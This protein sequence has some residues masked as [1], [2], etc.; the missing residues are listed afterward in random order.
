MNGEI[1]FSIIIPTYNRA[2]IIGKT[3]ESALG[4][5]F[6]NFE[7]IVVDDGGTD[8][9]EEVI[10]AFYSPKLS[11]YKKENAER[12]AARNFGAARGKGNYVTFLD[13]DDILFLS[14]CRMQKSAL[15]K[16]TSPPLFMLLMK[17]EMGRA[18]C[19][20]CVTLWNRIRINSSLMAIL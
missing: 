17:Y 7:I 3:I 19:F 14:T 10:Q 1:A 13:S 2:E 16:I 15:T 8:N 12:A 6:Q 4:Q 5:T 9:T 11:Y 20:P 18:N